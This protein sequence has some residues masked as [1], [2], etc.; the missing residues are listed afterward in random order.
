MSS[1]EVRPEPYVLVRVT[2]HDRDCNED[3]ADDADDVSGRCTVGNLQVQTLEISNLC[4]FIL[5]GTS[6][7]LL[8]PWGIN[9]LIAVGM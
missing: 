7:L 4:I 9:R 2:R 5:C 3:H 1:S 6:S 8:G